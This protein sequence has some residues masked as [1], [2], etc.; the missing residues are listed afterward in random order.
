MPV[1]GPQLQFRVAI[2]AQSRQIIVA[3]RKEID[4]GKRLRVAAV[5]PFSQPDD[6][7]QHPHGAAQRAVQIPIALV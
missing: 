2:G 3:A 1:G 5:E 7:R 4:P 6:C